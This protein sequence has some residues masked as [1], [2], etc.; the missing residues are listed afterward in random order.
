MIQTQLRLV[1]VVAGLMFGASATAQIATQN[2]ATTAELELARIHSQQVEIEAA[3]AVD[4]RACY[5]RFAV[6][7]CVGDARVRRRESLADLRRQE[8]AIKAAEARRRGAEQLSK[9]D[10]RAT[11]QAMREAEERLLEAQANQQARLKSIDE[12]SAE[13]ARLS[14]AAPVRTAEAKARE[15]ARA[16]ALKERAARLETLSANRREFEEKQLAAKKRQEDNQKRDNQKRL[17]TLKSATSKPPAAP[18][19]APPVPPASPAS[20]S[21]R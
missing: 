8:L 20:G 17:Q 5:Q 13:R 1:M 3:F 15:D 12:R 10:E 19:S 9:S 6:Y 4:E 14:Q 2:A 16:A 18:A 21:I 7:D 11:T